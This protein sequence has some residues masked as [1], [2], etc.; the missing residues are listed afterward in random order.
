[1]REH[2]LFHICIKPK[3]AGN[4]NVEVFDFRIV[5]E[6]SLEALTKMMDIPDISCMY[7]EE[8]DEI[9]IQYEGVVY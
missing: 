3:E 4:D 2:K 5:A 9:I 8:T 6:D 1:M 7:Y